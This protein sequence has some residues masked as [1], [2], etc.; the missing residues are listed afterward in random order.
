MAVQWKFK[1]TAGGN[2]PADLVNRVQTLESDNTTNK[3]NIA[4]NT[5]SI[6]TLESK[7]QEPDAGWIE[8]INTQV[9]SNHTTWT[10]IV[11][12][13]HPNSITG[14]NFF[15]NNKWYEILVQIKNSDFQR[16]YTTK[17]RKEAGVNWFCTTNINFTNNLGNGAN[18]ECY[19][20]IGTANSGGSWRITRVSGINNFNGFT[21][22]VKIRKL[23]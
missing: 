12:Q 3:T 14:N 1:N 22:V 18:S 6:T 23:V 9:T 19:A 13:A 4:T 16:N 10:D 8:L 7:I 21:V 15:E 5:T 17:A 11:Q 20:V 2:V